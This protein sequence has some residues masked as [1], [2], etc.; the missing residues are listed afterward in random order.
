MS[1]ETESQLMETMESEE[2]E[3]FAIQ[4][5][6]AQLMIREVIS[7]STDVSFVWTSLSFEN[8]KKVKW[9]EFR[10]YDRT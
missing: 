1:A 5:E 2:V 7:N 8:R 3:T 10:N 4:A 6:I 9:S